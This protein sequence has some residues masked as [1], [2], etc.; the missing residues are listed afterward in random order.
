VKI[1][2]IIQKYTGM[3]LSADEP[4]YEALSDCSLNHYAPVIH[5]SA[6]T[7]VSLNKQLLLRLMYNLL[8]NVQANRPTITIINSIN[9]II[10]YINNMNI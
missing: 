6:N 4:D 9:D 5:L 8:N 10:H 1:P 2:S 3:K 7:P